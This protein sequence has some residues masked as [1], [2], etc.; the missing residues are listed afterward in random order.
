MVKFTITFRAYFEYFSEGC[1]CDHRG[2]LSWWLTR[3]TA[4]TSDSMAASQTLVC[5]LRTASHHAMT[6]L[7]V[8]VNA[9]QNEVLKAKS[10]VGKQVMA[11]IFELFNQFRATET[12]CKQTTSELHIA[13]YRTGIEIWE[14][15]WA[16]R[17]V[18]V[19]RERRERWES[20]SQFLLTLW[21]H[22]IQNTKYVRQRPRHIRIAT[23]GGD[24]WP[25]TTPRH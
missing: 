16:T 13:I 17:S 4:T 23:R 7:R 1:V 14:K 21:V 19:Q 9:W 2:D 5:S 24:F 15:L 22:Q 18:V 3:T 11:S 25:C 12:E 10:C 8:C 6:T 20:C